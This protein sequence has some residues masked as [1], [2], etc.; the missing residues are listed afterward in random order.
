M[1]KILKIL[2]VLVGIVII[3]GVVFFVIDY[4]RVRKQENP[5]FCI[6][7]VTYKD[8]GT[9]EYLGLGYKVI[10]FNL[11][12]GYD[13]IKIGTWFMKYNDFNSEFKKY[14]STI[15]EII[16]QLDD[17]VIKLDIPKEWNYEE[18]NNSENPNAIFEL[19]L[20]KDSKE[21]S[22]SLFYY[23]NMFGV[24]GTGLESKNLN[25]NNG[26]E[27]NVGYYD[28]SSIWDFVGFGKYNR[29]I[30]IINNGLNENDANELLKIIKT[31]NIKNEQEEIGKVEKSFYGKVIESN[32]NTIIVEPNEDEEIR[33]SSD[34][35]AV[36]LGYTD[37]LYMV[38]TNV[39]IFYDGTVMETYPAQVK[40]IKIE[41]K[42]VDQFNLVFYQKTNIKPKQKETIINKGEVD[43]IDYAVYVFEGHVAINLN[44]NNSELSE[45]S[46]SLREALLQGKITMNE[47]I[48]KANK[49]LDENKITGDMLKDG[50][51]M[52]Y[53][54]D[55]YTI[56]KCHTLDGNRD[57]YLGSKDMSIEDLDIYNMSEIKK[58]SVIDVNKNI[59]MTVKTDKEVNKKGL[60]LE[61]KN[62]T[63]ELYV[64]GPE[65]SIEE[66]KD[67][68]WYEIETKYPL[69]WI[70]IAYNL[71]ANSTIELNIDW[72]NSYGE[73]PS[74][75]YR[76]VKKFIKDKDMP[77]TDEKI[78][79][80]E[81][82][83]AEFEIQ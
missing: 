33:K 75:T 13:D 74:G 56:I 11:V 46:I 39:K 28:G 8:G 7:N 47:I 31:L 71:E 61:I 34:K 40:A 29:N 44:S 63:E 12:N 69:T 42:S 81:K 57:V 2:F 62:N 79:K 78:E 83:F 70:A 9:K 4:N 38:G 19:K 30:A 67:S 60:T 26:M 16:K 43:N 24:C 22:A 20:Y 18:I 17:I 48:A 64:Y 6:N 36:G 65:Y 45:N 32:G 37:A 53:K 82:A 27:A 14:D 76:I 21:Q 55:N 68:R 77:I 59:T 41:L 35:I 80:T 50:G 5:I 54:Y 49:D 72:S 1:K 10:D 51:T 25:L 73:L 15:N 23:S 58:E 66:Q 3:L 52:I